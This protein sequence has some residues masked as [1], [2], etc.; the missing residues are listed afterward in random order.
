MHS[1]EFLE[2]AKIEYKKYENDY[3]INK[4]F[5]FNIRIMYM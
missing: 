3:I 2:R 1:K 4:K 5:Y